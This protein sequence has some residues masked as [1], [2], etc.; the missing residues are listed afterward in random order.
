[1]DHGNP[2]QR[3]GKAEADMQC[4]L[5]CHEIT[6]WGDVGKAPNPV[7]QAEAVAI[8]A[9]ALA[10]ARFRFGPSPGRRCDST[11][12]M[13]WPT[14]EG[15]TSCG[16]VSHRPHRGRSA[17]FGHGESPRSAGVP[18][19][20]HHPLL[21]GGGVVRLVERSQGG[22]SPL[23]NHTPAAKSQKDDWGVAMKAEE[24]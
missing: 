24:V 21:R 18:L 2:R 11:A 9:P 23:V 1:M 13:I 7:S 4:T 19:A 5:G 15:A 22:Y 17:S 14:R 16:P 20:V 3:H 6:R 12:K 10:R 8:A